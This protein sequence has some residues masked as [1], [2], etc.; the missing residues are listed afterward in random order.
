MVNNIFVNRGTL[1][2]LFLLVFLLT[3]LQA[4]AT[5]LHQIFFNWFQWFFLVL[6]VVNQYIQQY[7]D[8]WNKVDNVFSG[9]HSGFLTGFPAS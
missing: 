4:R 2:S 3:S 8:A 1:K 6:T 5:L 7:F 9:S